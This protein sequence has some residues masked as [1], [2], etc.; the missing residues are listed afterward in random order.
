MSIRGA[1]DNQM[2]QKRQSQEKHLTNPASQETHAYNTDVVQG[3]CFRGYPPPTRYLNSSVRKVAILE[4]CQQILMT[5]FKLCEN[6]FGTDV[7]K[8][9][10]LTTIFYLCQLILKSQGPY[11]G[12]CK[13][14]VIL[15]ANFAKHSPIQN[16][17]AT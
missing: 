2:T 6:K 5:F 11:F 4:P 8:F 9:Y 13:F 15:S 17:R 16:G 1:L 10:N 7:A 3:H 14:V 12:T